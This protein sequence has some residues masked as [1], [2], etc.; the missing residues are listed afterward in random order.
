MSLIDFLAARV[1]EDRALAQAAIEDI[2]GEDCHFDTWNPHLANHFRRHDPTRILREVAAKR[3]LLE[4]HGRSH[5]C[6]T[7]DHNGDVDSCSWYL[8]P[9][10]C[11]TLLALAAVYNDHPDYQQDWGS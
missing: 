10:D 5:E 8:N 9:T 1:E 3:A 11:S 7:Y 6:S 2:N 4:L